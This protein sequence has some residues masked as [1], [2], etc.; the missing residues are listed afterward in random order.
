MKNDIVTIGID[1]SST[2]LD[3]Y[4]SGSGELRAF[5]NTADGHALAAA[6]A[7]TEE[8]DMIA[9]EATGGYEK[10]LAAALREKGMVFA[11]LNPLNV[12]YYAKACS[13]YAKTDAIDARVIAEFALTVRPEADKGDKC[14][15]LLALVRRRKQLVVHKGSETRRLKQ[16]AFSDIK[17]GIE[18]CIHLLEEEIDDIDDAIKYIVNAQAALKEKYAVL[19][20]IKGVGVVAASSMLAHIPEL[21]KISHQKITSLVGLAP[22]SRDS[23]NFKG[24]RFIGGGRAEVR[25][26][27][28]MAALS[29]MRYNPDIK[30][31][32]DR[33]I[34]KGKPAK[35]A[36]VACMRKILIL[37]N[38][39]VRDN[40][41]W[42]QD[43]S[44][45]PV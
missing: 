23:G 5:D 27:L 25:H 18:R 21:G 38:A 44:A 45:Q 15:R 42:S 14:E 40:R 22:F 6:F 16:C 3:C 10:P 41:K 11:C 35:V 29:A 32:Y 33:L 36:L 4:S 13:T 37:A 2:R 19:H 30:A 17:H 34:A 43:F 12:R 20:S 8:A 31:V 26:D 24:K 1:V 39:L 7:T 9:F 28:Y